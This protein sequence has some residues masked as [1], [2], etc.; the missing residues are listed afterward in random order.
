M[1][2]DCSGTK[3]LNEQSI[4]EMCK[5]KGLSINVGIHYYGYEN[6]TDTREPMLAAHNDVNYYSI[7]NTDGPISLLTNSGWEMFSKN[8]NDSPDFL[9]DEDQIIVM[10]GL[11]CAILEGGQSSQLGYFWNLWIRR[12]C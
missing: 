5:E 2:R 1:A 12:R 7:I 4:G 8:E 6:S 9:L 10:K 11:S 3:W